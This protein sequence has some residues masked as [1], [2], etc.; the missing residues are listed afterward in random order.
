MSRMK[1]TGMLISAVT[2][3]MMVSS[4]IAVSAEELA[5]NFPEVVT[6]GL[7]EEMYEQ[8]KADGTLDERMEFMESL[9]N[10]P[11]VNSSAVDTGSIMS[12][13]EITDTSSFFYQNAPTTGNV[14]ALTFLVNF[15]DIKHPGS[16]QFTAEYVEELLNNNDETA[17]NYPY[18]SPSA[19]YNRSSYGK[20]NIDYDVYGWYESPNPRSYFEPNQEEG[21]NDDTGRN[22]LI[23]EVMDHYAESIDLSEYDSNND[24]YIDLVYF[25][26][27]GP[28]TGYGTQW[29]SYVATY[30][31][32]KTYDKDMLKYCFLNFNN[33]NTSDLSVTMIHETG[34]LFGLMDYYDTQYDIGELGGLGKIDMMDANI[35]DQNIFSKMLLGWAE[36]VIITS[37][38]EL[39][40]MPIDQS[41]TKAYIIK[42]DDGK[43]IFSEYF[44]IEYYRQKGNNSKSLNS[45][46][47]VK[48]YH[49]AA[50]G[51]CYSFFNSNDTTQHKLIRAVEADGKYV[52]GRYGYIFAPEMLYTSGM[53]FGVNTAPSTEFYNGTFT[54]INI[55]VKETG[56]ETAKVSVSFDNADE[57]GPELTGYSDIDIVGGVNIL[58]A[59]EAYFN[60]NIYS[61]ENIDNVT[62]CKKD[63]TPVSLKVNIVNGCF[64]E[65]HKADESNIDR[66]N[67]LEF[68]TDVSL[69]KDSEYIITIPEGTVKD[70]KGN[71]NKE[72]YIYINTASE[73][74][75]YTVEEFDFLKAVP[76]NAGDGASIEG[77]TER[78]QL[79][80]GNELFIQE[81]SYESGS[82]GMAFRIA[83]ADMNLLTDV[84][85]DTPTASYLLINAVELDNGNILIITTDFYFIADVSGNIVSSSS[86]DSAILTFNEHVTVRNDCV[87]VYCN[88]EIV[89]FALS[90]G[91][92]TKVDL[93][94]MYS[95]VEQHGT[96]VFDKD[97]TYTKNV[98]S[99]PVYDIL[100]TNRY[101]GF[102]TDDVTVYNYPINGAKKLSDYLIG[103]SVT[104]SISTDLGNIGGTLSNGYKY[105]SQKIDEYG[106]PMYEIC[107]GENLN[108]NNFFAYGLEDGGCLIAVPISYNK[109]DNW[110]SYWA[111]K[112][113]RLN[114]E[115]DVVW[116]RTVTESVGRTDM[117]AAY[118]KNGKVYALKGES[119]IVFDDYGVTPAE[120][121][122]DA[123]ISEA[124]GLTVDNNNH[125]LS[126][127][128][129]FTASE[130]KNAVTGECS[131]Y[132]YDKE[133]TLVEN[134]D[135][136]LE[137]A[138][139]EIVPSNSRYSVFY[140]FSKGGFAPVDID[141]TFSDDILAEAVKK[142]FDSNR[143]G[144]LSVYEIMDAGT[145]DIQNMGVESLGGIEVL[146]YLTYINAYGNKLSA[147]NLETNPLINGIYAENNTA[148]VQVSEQRTISADILKDF[149]PDKMTN[150]DGAD[151]NSESRIFENITKK[152]ISYN[153][154]CGNGLSAVFY[155][156]TGL[157][158]VNSSDGDYIIVPDGTDD[159]NGIIF[160]I[161]RYDVSAS[162]AEEIENAVNEIQ[163]MLYDSDA[164]DIE[165]TGEAE[166]YYKAEDMDN[167]EVW[168]MNDDG[169]LTLIESD[170][171]KEN[172]YIMF[173]TEVMGR[174]VI[175]EG[176]SSVSPGD[177]DGDGSI[178]N[179]DLTLLRRQ[180]ADNSSTAPESADLN[181]DGVVNNKDLVLLRRRL[182][183]YDI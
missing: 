144:S 78:F 35:G 126:A 114:S 28:D 66:Y 108:N 122:P 166:V 183:G 134:T 88:G 47:G 31:G 37:D 87:D 112:Y 113:I 36:P 84:C 53:S 95:Y 117:S 44:I 56:G 17:E 151:Y 148:E 153:Y 20:L 29:W 157:N 63:G 102:I 25:I 180:L 147:I 27:S 152:V 64:K 76:D 179:K 55:D 170:Y 140:T 90:D 23:E 72:E 46:G 174:I 57:I 182:A 103:T 2:A 172:A 104:Y 173:R 14:K 150:L 39:E 58:G 67:V 86:F 33:F 163:L 81:I 98:S 1:K 109:G 60:S 34:H 62:I 175:A 38:T 136:E 143:D 59:F 74:G 91:S 168:L 120:Q 156:N 131:V 13:S 15:S 69:D 8:Y 92:V 154:D 177:Y 123:V 129:A 94:N 4:S 124:S 24:G 6:D 107:I 105:I 164:V 142:H 93:G 50:D 158:I 19:Y 77:Y 171:D 22:L 30:T 139:V 141:K 41:G 106:V 61:G 42:P 12:L 51:N 155:I 115:L 111:T 26:Y 145:L 48:I 159:S 116:T 73:N 40:L 97:Y 127:D 96:A 32:D 82:A 149:V 71:V 70:S 65:A 167:P 128:K 83:D 89:R 100:N 133:Y 130:L 52:I 16:D 137:Y 68:I 119:A 11:S 165:L 181:N 178:N 176:E 162:V 9:I 80:N 21:F 101:N 138:V 169:T 132:V 118:I 146:K 7:S 160:N 85:L 18:E 99:M 79:E 75:S 45:D 43:G 3:M 110:T 10:V 54:G 49:V 125:R 5:G 121:V 135:T 161:N